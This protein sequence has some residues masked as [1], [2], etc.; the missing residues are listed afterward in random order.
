[1]K[2]TQTLVITICYLDFITTLI[3]KIYTKT[4][5]YQETEKYGW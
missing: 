5:V 2:P 1:M 3:E 4:M